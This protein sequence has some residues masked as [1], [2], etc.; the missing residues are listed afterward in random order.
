MKK[1]LITLTLVAATNTGYAHD[2][3]GC[4]NISNLLARL[5]CYDESH[6]GET[7]SATSAIINDTKNPTQSSSNGASSSDA[8]ST[9]GLPKRLFSGSNSNSE[10][11][12]ATL[13]EIFKHPKK[14]TKLYLD[15]KQV[16]GLVKERMMSASA[17]DAVR[18][19]T[20]TMGGYRMS[21]NDGSWFRV[22]R[23]K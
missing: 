11:V 6:G 2:A 18:I 21:I 14:M 15:N 19:K 3:A 13:T 10:A 8:N 23:L 7:T 17:G 22:K 1:T 4:S 12:Q 16:W 5:S 9:F 20:G